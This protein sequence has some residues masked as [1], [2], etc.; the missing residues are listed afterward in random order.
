MMSQVRRPA[1]SA[2]PIRQATATPATFPVSLLGTVTTFVTAGTAEPELVVV[3]L[4]G[5]V[6]VLK[7][8]EVVPKAAEVVL[9]GVVVLLRYVEV[10]LEDVVDTGVAVVEV[11]AG[12]GGAAPTEATSIAATNEDE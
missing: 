3:P 10:V 12:L 8:A 7:D 6:V 5:P 11:G 4:E 1:M 9:K 2:P